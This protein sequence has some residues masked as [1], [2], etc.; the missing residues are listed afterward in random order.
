MQYLVDNDETS[1][2]RIRHTIRAVLFQCDR[3][4]VERMV[5]KTLP[6]DLVDYS[7]QQGDLKVL[8]VFKKAEGKLFTFRI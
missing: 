5:T 8:V 2:I 3:K 7:E 4:I 1:E 6:A